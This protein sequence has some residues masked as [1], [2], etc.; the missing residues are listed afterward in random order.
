[1]TKLHVFYLCV[2][3]AN[4]AFNF[5]TVFSFLFCLAFIFWIFFGPPSHF[6]DIMKTFSPSQLGVQI[7]LSYLSYTKM[8]LLTPRY[9]V[10]NETDGDICVSEP[11]GQTYD[12]EQHGVSSYIREFV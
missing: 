12:V 11:H 4:F 2:L 3:I 1:M 7:Q 5:F 10:V 8:V 6:I 9:L